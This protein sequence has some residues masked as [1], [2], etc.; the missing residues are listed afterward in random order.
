MN[1]WYIHPYLGT[2]DNAEY[3]RGYF[4]G[5]SLLK[6]NINCRII[7]SSSHHL[8]QSEYNLVKNISEK[9]VSE[10]PFTWIKTPKYSGNGLK[11]IINMVTF[12]LKFRFIDLVVNHGHEKPDVIIISAAHPFHLLGG[13]HWAQKYKAKLIFEVRDIWPLSLN[14][15][16][17]M[18]FYHPFS[19][20]LSWFE[21]KAYKSVDQVVSLLPNAERHMQPRGLK[22][23]KFNYIPNGILI[24]ENNDTRPSSHRAYI[25]SLREKEDF[26]FMYTGAHGIPNA[27]E[28]LIMAAKIILDQGINRIKFV[29]VGDGVCKPNLIQYAKDHKIS[30][31]HFLEPIPRNEIPDTLTLSDMVFIGGRNIPLYEFGVSPNKMFEYMLAAKPILMTVKSPNNPLEL[32][33]SG[34][35]LGSNDPKIIAKEIIKYSCLSSKELEI[36]GNKGKKYV[37]KHHIYDVLAL[38]FLDVIKKID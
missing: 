2:P 7:T 38:Q 11:R 30:N 20:L 9:K 27:M 34:V 10:V 21:K 17:G 35:C 6:M 8:Q 29:L 5:S 19:L 12:G 31:V 3:G 18:S 28:P 22:S 32:A 24:D 15:L 16:L 25:N 14:Q 4:L 26:I 37:L 23:S 33:N 36:I 13:I 1:I